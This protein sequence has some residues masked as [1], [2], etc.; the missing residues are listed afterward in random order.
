M[1]TLIPGQSC[2][3]NSCNSCKI[4]YNGRKLTVL[5]GLLLNGHDFEEKGKERALMSSKNKI[6]VILA[7][8]IY[9]L[10][11]YESEEYLQKVAGYLNTKLSEF[12]N[13]DGY[14]RLSPEMRAILLDLNIA[15]DYFKMKKKVEELEGDLS[16]KDQELYEFKHQIITEQIQTENLQKECDTLKKENEGLREEL[17]RLKAQLA[18]DGN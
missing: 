10:S 7:G 4:V 18:Q 16:E 2:K 14:H 13:L 17:I 12:Q 1:I 3:K 6:Q 11:G 8:K 5:R 15:D 9:T